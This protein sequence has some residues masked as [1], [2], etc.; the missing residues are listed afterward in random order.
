MELFRME[1]KKLWRKAIVKI[2]VLVCFAYVVLFG[3]ILSFQWFS[4]GS[5]SGYETGFGNNF[6]GYSVIRGS[7]EYTAPFRGDLTDE[8][9]QQLVRDYQR[10][11]NAGMTADLQRTD[12]LTVNTW[13]QMLWP[14]EKDSSSYNVIKLVPA[15]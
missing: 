4:L 3:S 8:T 15:T 12:Y 13:L 6:D 5:M 9:V 14:E 1:H 11:Y 10:M 7:Q 2:C